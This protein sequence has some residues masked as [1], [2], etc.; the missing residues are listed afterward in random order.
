MLIC[1]LLEARGEPRRTHPR[2][3]AM[4]SRDLRRLG[5]PDGHC[6]EVAW[7]AIA[8]ARR[9]GLG[10]RETRAELKQ[11]A[12][13]PEAHL[14]H[15]RFGALADLLSRAAPRPKQRPPRSGPAPHRVWGRDHD[16]E[17]FRQMQRKCSK[18]L[19][20][21]CL[22]LREPAVPP[23]LRSQGFYKMNRETTIPVLTAGAY[24]QPT[25]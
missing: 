24:R 16:P 19:G 22:I 6:M 7:E 20:S 2:R 9:E 13:N 1:R 14:E 4:K 8:L 10:L 21:A 3:V 25:P 17:A 15:P 5:I 12:R 18:T 11:V 23:G